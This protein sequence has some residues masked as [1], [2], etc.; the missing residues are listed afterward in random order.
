MSLVFS[1]P[2]IAHRGASAYAPENTMAAFVKAVQL[3]I[4]WIEFDVM[5]TV[6]GEPIIF[7]DETLDRTTN[8]QGEVH[9][10]SYAYLQ[11]LDAGAWY[12]PFFSGEKIPTLQQVLQFMREMKI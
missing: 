3:G 9:H 2:V 7:H 1:P 5:A 10:H 12:Q 11:T 4:K 8:A 6:N